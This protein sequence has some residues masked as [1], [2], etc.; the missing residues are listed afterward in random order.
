MKSKSPRPHDSDP[1][2]PASHDWRGWIVP[3]LVTGA[4]AVGGAIGGS[5]IANHGAVAVQRAQSEHDRESE[6]RHAKGSARL[7][8]YEILIAITYTHAMQERGR[9]L[10]AGAERVPITIPPDDL[11]LVAS[12][13]TGD[14]WGELLVAMGAALFVGNLMALLRRRAAE[15]AGDDTPAAPQAP[16][17]RTVTFM[18]MGFVVAFW[19]LASLLAR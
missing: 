6:R 16:V 1:R 12:Y 19:G 14:E 5:A 3:A 8:V 13:V 10:R 9:W 11:R 15:P 18:L 7:L 2:V 4:F 17:K